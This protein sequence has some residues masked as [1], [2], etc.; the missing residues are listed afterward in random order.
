MVLPAVLCDP[1]LDPEQ[2]R[3][4]GRDVRLDPDP[5]LPAV[6]R[7][8]AR[9]VRDL[10]AALQAIL[11]GIRAGVSRAW[12]SRCKARRRRLRDRGADPHC[13]L[14]HSLSDHP[15]AARTDRDA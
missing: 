4:R 14:F 2:A 1:A 10:P 5:L 11:L 8:L 3:G 15:A 6:A 13:L 7:Y 9:E 12:L